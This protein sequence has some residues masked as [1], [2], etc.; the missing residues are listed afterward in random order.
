MDSKA[1]IKALEKYF[2]NYLIDGDMKNCDITLGHMKRMHGSIITTMSELQR[3]QDDISLE[4][5]SDLSILDKIMGNLIIKSNEQYEKKVDELEKNENDKLMPNT[6]PIDSKPRKLDEKLPSLVLF[7]A[8]WCG[9]CQQFMPTWD[10]MDSN[11]DHSK[12]NVVKYS[13][14]T[15]EKECSTFIRSYPSIYVYIPESKNQKSRKIKFDD[16]R[17]VSNIKKFVKETTDVDILVGVDL[18]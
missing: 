14:V 3:K 2:N 9:P 16:D 6:K 15:Y 11:I 1:K 12:I 4:A 7:F 10:R 13:C 8:D 17:T 5:K 18:S